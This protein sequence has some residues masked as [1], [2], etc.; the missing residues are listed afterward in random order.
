M[1]E[2]IK[3]LGQINPST[4]TNTVLYT[5]PANKVCTISS[6][7][8]CNIDTS[9]GTFRIFVKKSADSIPQNKQY[10]YYD[11]AIDAKSTYI[12]TIGITLSAG[13][14][15]YVYASSANFSFN[16]FGVEVQ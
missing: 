5:V 9:A 10:I 3:I 2:Y 8:A 16:A 1:A 11:Q 12:A 13:D 7:T 4:T 6:I 14:V 15:I